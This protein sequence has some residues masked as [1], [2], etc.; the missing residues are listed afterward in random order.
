M[1]KSYYPL[2]SGI[3]IVLFICNLV[4][5]QDGP[6]Y[7]N[8]K[9]IEQLFLNDS[10]QNYQFAAWAYSFIGE[11][12]KAL[13]TYDKSGGEEPEFPYSDI[14]ILSKYQVRPAVDYIIEQSKKEKII[15]INE[16]HHQPAH[17]V[18]TESLLEGLY[19]NGYRY[20]GLET[21]AEDSLLNIRKWPLVNDGY[22]SREPQFGNMIRKALKIGFTL[23]CYEDLSDPEGREIGEAK[24]IKKII[25]KDERAKILI[26]CGFG[27]LLEDYNVEPLRMAGALKKIS[28]I[29]P[30]S[31]D[32]V[33]WT[34]HSNSAYEA[35]YYQFAQTQYSAVFI[36]TNGNPYNMRRD[37]S[38]VDLKVAHPRTQ[39]IS[40]RP[41]WLLRNDSWKE[42]KLDKIKFDINFP[43]LI[44]AYPIKEDDKAESVPIDQ[45]EINNYGEKSLI[46]PPGTFILPLTDQNGRTQKRQI[47]VK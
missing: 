18:F 23:F 22:Y 35:R 4:H 47:T 11:Y 44:S 46:L 15:I 45:I 2:V 27:H 8:S 33:D 34:E 30:F 19:K 31:I 26:H 14:N 10:T 39:Y 32:Q 6:D 40:K 9:Q 16:A 43:C 42:Y 5:A 28:G 7:K 24:N 13:K 20:L 37:S 41:S 3:T 25:D 38:L 29:D 17:R 1:K 21:L 36:D 12:H